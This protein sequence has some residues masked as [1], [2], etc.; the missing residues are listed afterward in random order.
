MIDML[1]RIAK[2]EGA[3]I[4]HDALALITRAAEGSARDAQSLLDQAISH[5]AGETT[6]EQVRAMLGL[7]D[8]GRVL[9]LFDMI[10]KGDAAKALGELGAQYSDGA[11]PL[12]IL[13]DLA[14][15]T[16]WVSVVKITPDAAEDP[17]I[18]PDERLRGQSFAQNI[19][20]A[21]LNSDL[22]K[23]CSKRWKKWQMPQT[24]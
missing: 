19:A 20:H 21:G 9:D 17:T 6:V 23:C 22:A 4:A 3:A 7:A 11:D 8:R 10:M 15:V 2:A 1:S 16:H 5:G 12:A 13:R 18:S 14:E 24:A